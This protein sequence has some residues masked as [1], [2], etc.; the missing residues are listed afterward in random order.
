MASPSAPAGGGVDWESR[1]LAGDT[2]WDKGR[3]H[4]ALDAL[5]ADVPL[6]GHILVPG[7][8]T[9]HDVRTLAAR[10]KAVVV[11][12]DIA[13]SAI[14]RASAFPKAG[15][16]E[17]V[18]GDFLAGTITA[19]FDGLF[20]HTCFCA[21][22]PSLRAAYARAAAQAV[23]P[24]GIFLA[25]FYRD[26]GHESGPPFGCTVEELNTLFLPHFELVSTHEGFETFEGRECREL[27]RVMRRK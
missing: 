4:P 17:Y 24:G 25:V 19:E 21:I 10:T 23:K 11:G 27:G 7:C 3:S 18:L 15:R 2:P 20:E 12:M 1:Y 5:L 13:P 16:E 6:S 22:D 14:A 26:P 9:G 8:G